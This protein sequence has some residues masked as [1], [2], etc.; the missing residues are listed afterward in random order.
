MSMLTKIIA[1]IAILSIGFNLWQWYNPREIPAKGKVVYLPGEE[2]KVIVYD[3]PDGTQSATVKAS[4]EYKQATKEARELIAA[5]KGIPDLESVDKI[6]A[7]TGAKMNL[8]LELNAAKMTVNDVEKQRKTWEDKY[9]K[10]IVDNSTNTASV[11]S[12][13]NPIIATVE[14]REAF[15]KPK[16]SYTVVTSKNP[17]VKFYGLESYQFK[18]PRPKDFVELNLKLQGLYINKTLI[19]YAGAELLFNPDGR[20]KPLVGYGYFYDPISGKFMPYGMA[21]MQ[22]NL[23]RF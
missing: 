15:Y 2:R 9:N 12:E 18:N 23:I 3:N 4:Q 16:E 13:V 14:K 21:G 7:L 6:A 1:I 20:L 10:V 19:P 11:T 8:E 17:A 5:V 22:L